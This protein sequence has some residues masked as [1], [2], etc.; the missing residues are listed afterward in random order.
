[1]R[2][3][4]LTV[5]RISETHWTHAGQHRLGREEE[6]NAPHMQRVA[7]TLSE[8]ARNALVG[9]E[10]SGSLI[11]KTPFKTKNVGITMNVVQYYALTNNSNDDNIDQFYE[12]LQSIIAKFPGKN[13]TILM[14]DLSVKV[15]MNNSGFEDIM[16]RYGLGEENVNGER[17][18]NLYPFNKMVIDDTIF[19]FA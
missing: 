16:G 11:I 7:P 5:L 18:A 1:M 8:E 17:F 12:R 10:S 4:N 15:V 6:E 2:K 13:L 9:S 14:G 19:N 3:Y